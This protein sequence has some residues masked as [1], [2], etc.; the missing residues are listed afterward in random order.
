MI[1][2]TSVFCVVWTA[3][4]YH[5]KNNG[6]LPAARAFTWFNNRAYSA[7]SLILLALIILYSDSY[8]TKRLYH[9]SK[10][11]E[12]LDILAVRASGGTIGL[13]FAV[14]HLTTPYMT[15]FR[16]LQHSEK[17]EIVASLNALHHVF[18]YAYFGGATAARRVLPVTGTAQLVVGVLGEAFVLYEKW[19]EDAFPLWPNVF[20][21]CLL[22]LYLGLWVG[23]LRSMNKV[24]GADELDKKE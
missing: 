12:Y 10:F 7:A 23:E 11:Y 5:V 4:H 19:A 14:H 15:Y 13:H 17:W 22:M 8:F 24:Q 21:L 3:L 2:Q 20:T 1:A 6:A 18:M 16:V 9:Y